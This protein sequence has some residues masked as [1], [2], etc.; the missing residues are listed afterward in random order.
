MPAHY[1]LR[2]EKPKNVMSEYA[3]GGRVGLKNRG[4]LEPIL[5]QYKKDQQRQ[6]SEFEQ[7][8]KRSKDRLRTRLQKRKMR[9]TTKK[10][11]PKKAITLAVGKGKRGKGMDTPALQRAYAKEAQKKDPYQDMRNFERERN[12]RRTMATEDKDAPETSA[13]QRA[14]TKE[15]Q[16]KDPYE[17]M[18]KFE[19][20][21][22][23][24]ASKRPVLR[25][26]KKK[27]KS[28]TKAEMIAQLVRKNKGTKKEL[29]K[30]MTSEIRK[31][32][33]KLH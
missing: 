5:S 14:F 12:E 8:K 11:K 22:E 33:N 24:K 27:Q 19:R 17:D 30:K 1:N 7:Q 23:E 6:K 15:A 32:F 18:R 28:F 4:E 25:Y 29:E 16:K 21:R 20:E 3:R 10:P 9:E 31:M 26:N 13:L 2:R